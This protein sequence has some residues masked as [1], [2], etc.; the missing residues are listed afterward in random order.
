MATEN[1]VLK[2]NKNYIKSPCHSRGGTAEVVSSVRS[3]KKRWDYDES[4]DNDDAIVDLQLT[5]LLGDNVVSLLRNQLD[6]YRNR[7]RHQ[8]HCQHNIQFELV[9][10]PEAPTLLTANYHSDHRAVYLGAVINP[11][12]LDTFK[13]NY[14]LKTVSHNVN[15]FLIINFNLFPRHILWNFEFFVIMVRPNRI[16]IVQ[17]IHFF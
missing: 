17:T 5:L 10:M 12:L 3:Y 2:T 7:N 15:I 4:L 8:H 1:Y 13:I 11:F 14:N 16:H 9:L 6:L